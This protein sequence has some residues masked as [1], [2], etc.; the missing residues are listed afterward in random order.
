MQERTFSVP[1]QP[2]SAPSSVTYSCSHPGWLIHLQHH[3]LQ[4]L[5]CFFVIGVTVGKSM[6]VNTAATHRLTS[7]S[8]AGLFSRSRSAN[9]S[10]QL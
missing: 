2:S 1:T 8:Q 10:Q 6:S 4:A 9:S 5:G 7:S 3:S